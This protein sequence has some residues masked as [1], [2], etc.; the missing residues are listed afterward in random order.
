MTK[1][2]SAS[3]VYMTVLIH[4]SASGS[5][6]QPLQDVTHIYRVNERVIYVNFR[7]LYKNALSL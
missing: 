3:D 1:F 2:G 7:N 4:P 6:R 5:H